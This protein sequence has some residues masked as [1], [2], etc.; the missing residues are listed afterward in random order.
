V[1]EEG[2]GEGGG[3][4]APVPCIGERWHA[5]AFLLPSKPALRALWLLSWDWRC[6]PPVPLLCTR[7]GSTGR[8]SLPRPP[9]C[10]ALQ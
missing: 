8:A 10:P 3:A 5:S 9:C 1:R 6:A 7:I 4:S 2:E